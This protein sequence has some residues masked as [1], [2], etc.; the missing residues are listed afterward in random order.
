MFKLFIERRRIFIDKSELT[1]ALGVLDKY[2]L[3]TSTIADLKLGR[4]GWKNS[5]N[6]WFIHVS[7]TDK[8]WF[9]VLQDF[10]KEDVK[11]LP[12]TQRYS[13]E[14]RKNGS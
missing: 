4:C 12:E 8:T 5:P 10:V 3:T 1:K 11:I 7:T 14:N 13:N 6:C 2:D 9:R